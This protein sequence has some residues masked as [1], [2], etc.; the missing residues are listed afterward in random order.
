M[1]GI[2]TARELGRPAMNGQGMLVCQAVLALEHFLG[3]AVDREAMTAAAKSA[4]AA[5][6][7][8]FS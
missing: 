8:S 3:R 4:L 2:E 7:P 6:S 5:F 1:D